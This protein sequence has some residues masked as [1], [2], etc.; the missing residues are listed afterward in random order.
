M[1]YG[2]FSDVHSNLEAFSAVLEAYS[3]EKIDK[4]CCVGDIVG[5]GANP[6]ECIKLIREFSC[7][8]VKGNHDVAACDLSITTNFNEN[9]ALAAEWTFNKISQP[10]KD[11][12]SSLELIFENNDF[13][14]VHGSLNKPEDFCYIFDPEE[15]RSSFNFQEK[16]VCFVGHSHI[17]GVFRKTGHSIELLEFCDCKFGKESQYIVNVGSVGQPRDS[18][19]R[20]VYCVYDTEERSVTIRRVKYDINQAAKKIRESGLPDYLAERLY[21]GR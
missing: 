16:Q 4:Y 14:L 6:S 7:R 21:K 10:D 3:I 9:A 1:R 5:Y 19:N 12:L 11:Y 8:V 15:A 20:A 13:V 2:I 18:D 17:P